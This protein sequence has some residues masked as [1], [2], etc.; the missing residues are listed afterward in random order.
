MKILAFDI[1]I[2]NLAYCLLEKR[3]DG[4]EILKWEN[5]NLYPEEEDKQCISMCKNG[6]KCKSKAKY[7]YGSNYYCKKHKCDKSKK[8]KKP[9]N[10]KNLSEYT[11]RIQKTFSKKEFML[12]SDIILLE[13]QSTNPRF[14]NFQMK[15]LQVIIFSYFKFKGKNVKGVGAIKKENLVKKDKDWENTDYKKEYD[16][17]EKTIKKAYDK[18]KFLCY[19]YGKYV[20]RNF[21]DMITFLE[22]HKKKD[23]LVDAFL[24]CINHKCKF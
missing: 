5:I 16:E 12:D 3:V 7:F 4:F 13:N 19:C 21:P 8:I 23:D 17:K 2:K 24:M 14:S 1:G 22:S 9:T 18:R 10:N 11:E 6:K 20:L 15:N